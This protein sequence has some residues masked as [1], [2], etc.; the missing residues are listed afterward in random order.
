[1]SI[2]A[3]EGVTAPISNSVQ[4]ARVAD[5]AKISDLA[6]DKSSVDKVDSSESVAKLEASIQKLNDLM[7]TGQR[8]LS[9]SVDNTSGAVI[10]KVIDTQTDEVIRQIPNEESLR[11]AEYIDGMVGMIF[12][13]NA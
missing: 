9:F 11:F 8:S 10:I 2:E 6:A 5:S 3:T 4:P 12:N 13:R 7:S 1:M